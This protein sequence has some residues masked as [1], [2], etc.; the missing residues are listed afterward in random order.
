MRSR[1]TNLRATAANANWWPRTRNFFSKKCRTVCRLCPI[2]RH[3]PRPIDNC[4]SFPAASRY[5]LPN[6]ML[7][8]QRTLMGVRSNFSRT[9]VN[10]RASN[11][12]TLPAF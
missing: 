12:W 5:C 3:R 11:S 2:L 10:F 1:N 4:C 6:P 8:T 7:L 9:W